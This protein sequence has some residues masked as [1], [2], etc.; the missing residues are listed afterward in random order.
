VRGGNKQRDDH[1]ER[2]YQ[3]WR[4]RYLTAITPEGDC[5][6]LALMT[7]DS[8]HAALSS[9]DSQVALDTLPYAFDMSAPARP[10][11]AGTVSIT[12]VEDGVRAWCG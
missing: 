11:T 6:K 5:A 12:P 3:Q 7:S 10:S 1:A 8:I 9:T 2:P 4:R